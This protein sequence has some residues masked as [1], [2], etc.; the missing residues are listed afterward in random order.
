MLQICYKHP[1]KA[2]TCT[3]VFMKVEYKDE[4]Y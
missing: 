3:E 1:T 4:L 2:I